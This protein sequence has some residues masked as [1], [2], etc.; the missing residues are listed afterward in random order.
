MDTKNQESGFSFA[1]QTNRIRP[2]NEPS[3]LE[4]DRPG[5]NE[6]RDRILATAE[7]VSGSL[8]VLS[9]D[10]EALHDP[11]ALDLLRLLAECSKDLEARLRAT[12]HANKPKIRAS[13][14]R[15]RKQRR[16]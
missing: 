5:K 1:L 15:G 2:W 6:F 10:L 3:G 16:A 9:H 13:L 12:L 8:R 4:L 11:G 7:Q 14:S